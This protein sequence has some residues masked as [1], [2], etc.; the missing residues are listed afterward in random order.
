[1]EKKQK[2][3]KD[4][5]KHEKESAASDKVTVEPSAAKKSLEVQLQMEEG[6]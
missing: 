6:E 1:M 2:K 3:K 5:K 4:E